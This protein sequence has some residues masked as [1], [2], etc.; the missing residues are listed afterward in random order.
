[1][2]FPKIQAAY[3]A[4]SEDDKRARYDI[5]AGL[6]PSK[7]PTRRWREPSYDTFA[8]DPPF[9]S[10]ELR[11]LTV[12]KCARITKIQHLELE[13]R[14]LVDRL[15]DLVDAE[16]RAASRENKAQV[17]Y[18]FLKP[19]V[20]KVNLE[21]KREFLMNSACINTH[22]HRLKNELRSAYEEHKRILQKDNVRKTWWARER[23]KRVEEE[24]RRAAT[25]AAEA[26]AARRR[27]EET[28]RGHGKG[29]E[30]AAR[31][32]EETRRQAQ[33]EA[34]RLAH[35]ARAQEEARKRAEKQRED[36]EIAKKAQ[37]EAQEWLAR[38]REDI[39]GRRSKEEGTKQNIFDRYA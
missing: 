4:L 28:A 18:S 38:Q 21:R 26:E 24:N 20:P 29:D 35:T 16:D 13:I 39:L 1:M 14:D 7:P 30:E 9:W 19:R 25:R 12:Q 17:W 33:E 15:G 23:V 11:E 10:A 37:R 36:P 27:A 6:S 5:T 22:L 3:E 34:T 31:T 8:Q 2:V 32:A